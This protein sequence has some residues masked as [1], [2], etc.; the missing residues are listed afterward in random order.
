M[1]VLDEPLIL[2]SRLFHQAIPSLAQPTPPP[3]TALTFCHDVPLSRQDLT[4][5]DPLME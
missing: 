5:N 2:P 1:R 4:F 3:Y